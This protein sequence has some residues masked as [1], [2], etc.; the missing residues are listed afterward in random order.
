[1][2]NFLINKIHSFVFL[3][4]CRPCFVCFSHT[5]GLKMPS[6]IE[7][8][9][10]A[11][12]VEQNQAALKVE[13]SWS[14]AREG[15]KVRLALPSLVDSKHKNLKREMW[16]NLLLFYYWSRW[17]RLTSEVEIGWWAQVDE[18]WVQNPELGDGKMIECSDVRWSDDVESNSSAP[19]LT[20]TYT[21]TPKSQPKHTLQ[22]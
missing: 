7:G 22:T 19:N 17:V 14:W 18:S 2:C 16:L 9:N 8:H 15:M 3:L 12:A 20:S 6:D 5:E 1:M 10:Q 13:D 21:Q 4:T 11:S